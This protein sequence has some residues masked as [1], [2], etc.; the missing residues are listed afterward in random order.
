MKIILILA[1][2]VIMTASQASQETGRSLAV[3]DS[4]PKEK[5]TKTQK[6]ENLRLKLEKKNLI[7]VKKQIDAIRKRYK[8]NLARKTQKSSLIIN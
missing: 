7:L 3:I 4:S 1:T 8:I 5:L 2:L 6:I